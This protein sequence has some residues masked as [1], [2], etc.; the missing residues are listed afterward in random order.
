[1]TQDGTSGPDGSADREIC[2]DDAAYVLGALSPVDRRAYEEHLRECSACQAS[3]RSLAGLPGLLA[4]TSADAL[5]G[6]AHAVPR[7]GAVFGQRY[8]SR[9][10][11][12]AKSRMKWI[13]RRT[14][15]A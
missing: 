11:H 13:T 5:T 2:H 9:I 4:L 15:G 3:V 6:P 7:S 14:F 12:A 10:R 1:M 8:R